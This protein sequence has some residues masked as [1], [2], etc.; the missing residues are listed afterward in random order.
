MSMSRDA[1]STTES[2]HANDAESTWPLLSEREMNRLR[3]LA[4]C[5]AD[6][7]I[8]SP[9]PVRAEVDALCDEII[10]A[11]AAEPA[12]QV[13]LVSESLSYPRGRSTAAGTDTPAWRATLASVPPTFAARRDCD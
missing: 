7:R 8:R 6:G 11:L 1:A 12:G 3:F 10:A 13:P 5:R 2:D 4:Y 9:A